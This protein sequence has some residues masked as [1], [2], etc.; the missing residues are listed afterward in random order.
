[1]LYRGHCEEISSR[2]LVVSPSTEYPAPEILKWLEQ[3][4]ALKEDLD[5]RWAAR[6][7]AIAR[8]WDRTVLVTEDPGGM[9]LDQLLEEPLSL[10]LWL[11]LAISLST[12][13][14]QLHQRGVIHK[15]IKPANILVESASGRCWL[16]GFFVASQR[17]DCRQSIL[18]RSVYFHAG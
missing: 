16:R 18:R 3:E 2:V 5:G 1:M 8:Y 13:I 7:T 15:D 12:G 9:P 10:G 6:P 11:R 4:Y 17:Q 14:D